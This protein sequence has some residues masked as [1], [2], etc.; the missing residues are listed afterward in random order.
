MKKL[1]SLFALALVIL[2]SGCLEDDFCKELERELGEN[3]VTCHCVRV[4][5][6]PEGYE[7]LSAEPKC[8]CICYTDY[9]W[10]NTTIAVS[11]SGGYTTPKVLES[12]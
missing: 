2:V 1:I 3:N 5:I 7:N 4:E 9:G 10:V 8:S 6:I 11:E 12:P